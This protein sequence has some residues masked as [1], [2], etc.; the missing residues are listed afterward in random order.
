VTTPDT[1]S[2]TAYLAQLEGYQLH[3]LLARDPRSAAVWI[4][5]TAVEGLASAQMCYGRML[6]EGTGV[7]KD[8]A[9]AL[10][11]FRR[12]AAS[13]DSDPIKAD[14][15]KPDAIRLDAINMVGRCFDNG[16][17]TAVDA[18]AAAHHYRTAADAGHTWAQYNLGHLYLDGR[19]VPRDFQQAFSYYRRAAEQGHERAMNLLGRCHEEG[20]GTPRDSMLAATWYRRSAEGGYFRGQYNWAS[21]LLHADRFDEAA[22]WFER[23]AVGGTDGV[24]QA[25]LDVTRAHASDALK[26]LAVR[27]QDTVLH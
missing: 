10:M 19:G 26:A 1:T 14:T 21:I 6:L 22:L 9:A 17:G 15:I 27:L 13:G 18:L 12:A 24:R 20:W 7:A 5:A 11:W 3:A 2:M 25:V 23:A 4:R 8:Q 16:W